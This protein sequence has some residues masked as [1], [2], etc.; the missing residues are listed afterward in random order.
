MI[1]IKK[2][3]LTSEH[4]LIQA[5]DAH[6][7]MLKDWQDHM[8][9]VASDALNDKV[10][11]ID[12]H[13]AYPRPVPDALVELIMQN[14]GTYT[15]IDD[16]PTPEEQL[17]VQKKALQSS[18]NTAEFAAFNNVVSSAKRVLYDHRE[19]VIRQAD[20]DKAEAIVEER[21]TLKAKVLSVFVK[22]EEVSKGVEDIRSPEDTQFLS[23]QQG[24]REKLQAI[25]LKAAQARSDIED[26]TVVTIK[27]WKN[28]EL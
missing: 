12:K 27:S 6:K 19:N 18:L 1:S 14:G 4:A 23:E 7:G 24:R 11:P 2:S 16:T 25:N 5:L 22:P 3:Q 20:N 8:R 28:P 9:R 13:A 21:S 10:K 17:V 15:I 26:L